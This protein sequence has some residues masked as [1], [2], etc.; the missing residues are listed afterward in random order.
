MYGLFDVIQVRGTSCFICHSYFI[1]NPLV[2]S[3]LIT[4][5]VTGSSSMNRAGH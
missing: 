5:R 1:S 3:D 2:S 4:M